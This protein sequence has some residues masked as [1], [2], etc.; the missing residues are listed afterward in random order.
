[1]KKVNRNLL[2]K[3]IL[4]II[5]LVVFGI[6][7]YKTIYI[8]EKVVVQLDSCIDGDTALFIVDEKREKVRLLGIDTPEST[9]KIEEYGVMASNYTC[10][11]LKSANYIYL[12]FDSNIDYR[13]KYSRLLAYVF[14]DG[15]NLSELL[16]KEGLAEVKYI[17][18]DYKYIDRLCE[19]QFEAY[20][21]KLGIWN[22]YD[23]SKNY[24]YNIDF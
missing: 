15:N 4:V 18:G 3:I 14:V 9:N 21:N 16:L 23:Y 7:V 19:K 6:V 22:I 20:N 1:M 12:E 5:S 13:D 2:I 8:D 24:C 17:Y 11:I 10:N